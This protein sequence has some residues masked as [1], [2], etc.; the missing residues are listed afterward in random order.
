[1]MWHEQYLDWKRGNE[2][3]GID[4]IVASGRARRLAKDMA[5]EEFH[6]NYLNVIENYLKA[7]SQ[8]DA[9]LYGALWEWV[10]QKPFFP[11]LK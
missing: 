2:G 3:D 6:D 10:A 7:H 1:M 4:V 11:D 5:R 9:E 8:G